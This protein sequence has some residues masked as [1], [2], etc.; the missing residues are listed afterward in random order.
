MQEMS[1]ALWPQI[2]VASYNGSSTLT[3]GLTGAGT[4]LLFQRIIV[5][6]GPSPEQHAQ[7]NQWH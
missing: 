3:Q 5:V 6:Q 7:Q 2:Y 1:D 4:R